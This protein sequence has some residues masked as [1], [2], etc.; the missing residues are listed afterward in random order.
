M[1]K[2]EL[3]LGLAVAIGTGSVIAIQTAFLSRAGAS[4]GAVRGGLLTTMTGALLAAVILFIFWRQNPSNW[5]WSTSTW[6]ALIL[7]G[8]L[9]TAALV[10][11]SYSA[12][13]VGITAALASILLGQ[14][15]VSVVIDARGLGS[16]VAIPFS[17]ERLLGMLLLG[18]G[19]YL[20]LFRQ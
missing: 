15:L 17:G 4:A 8:I 10:G 3:F 6:L 11:I 20:L 14:M 19:V 1:I 12:Q 2:N 7:G 9:G 18:G 5:Q 13:R 16:T